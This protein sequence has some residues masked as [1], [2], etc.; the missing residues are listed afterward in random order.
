MAVFKLIKWLPDLVRATD[1]DIALF[2]PQAAQVRALLNYIPTMS[3]DAVRTSRV[4]FGAADRAAYDAARNAADDFVIS[5]ADSVARFAARGAA[6]SAADAAR[7]GAYDAAR[8]AARDAARGESVSDLISP[9]NY[10]TLTNPLNTGRVYNLRAP[11][12]GTKFMSLI[13][14]LAPKTADDVELIADLSVNPQMQGI[15]ELL[16]GL[17]GGMPLSAKIDAARRLDRVSRAGRRLS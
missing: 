5:A 11:E 14:D 1:D 4:A 2:G 10:R 17:Q 9:E 15:L 13:R 3:D 8:I 12:A 6:G 7:G 16:K